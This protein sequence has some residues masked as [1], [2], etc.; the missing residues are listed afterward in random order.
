MKN[1][2]EAAIPLGT[3]AAATPVVLI[4]RGGISPRRRI[5]EVAAPVGAAEPAAEV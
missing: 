1:R 5:L 3:M 2:E 4:C